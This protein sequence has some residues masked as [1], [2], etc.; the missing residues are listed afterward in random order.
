MLVAL[1]IVL[2]FPIGWFVRHRLTAYVA[3]LA[4][5][6]FLFT[7]QSTELIIDW[8]GGDT[9]AFGGFPKAGKGEAYSYGLVNLIFLAVGLGLL[10]LGTI[11]ASRRRA[12]RAVPAAVPVDA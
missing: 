3:Y 10:T 7:F 4:A 6:S 2:P 11:L 1:M 9:R 12:R 8:A 5:F